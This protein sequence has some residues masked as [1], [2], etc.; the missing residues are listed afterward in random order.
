VKNVFERFTKLFG[1]NTAGAIVIDSL[2]NFTEFHNTEIFIYG[3]KKFN[4]KAIIKVD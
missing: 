4:N 2:G 1:K 3:C